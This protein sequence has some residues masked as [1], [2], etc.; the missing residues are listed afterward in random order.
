[1]IIVIA[2]QFG[3]IISNAEEIL[4]KSRL[5]IYTYKNMY[6]YFGLLQYVSDFQHKVHA[7]LY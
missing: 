5:I 6:S 3:M 7:Q 4:E 1:M 2:Q